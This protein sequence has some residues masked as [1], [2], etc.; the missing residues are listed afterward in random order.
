MEQFCLLGFKLGFLLID[1]QWEEF[2]LKARLCN[3]VVDKRDKGN[4]IRGQFHAGVSCWQVKV[5]VFV[6]LDCFV[7]DLYHWSRTVLL[8]VA[9]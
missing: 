3:G 6:V 1:N 7:A 9:F 5:E 2:T 4:C 8:D